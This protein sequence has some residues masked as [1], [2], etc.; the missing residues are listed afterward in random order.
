MEEFY[1]NN[2]GG[3]EEKHQNEKGHLV[4]EISND[5]IANADKLDDWAWQC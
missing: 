2:R 4:E 5:K 1:D 3:V